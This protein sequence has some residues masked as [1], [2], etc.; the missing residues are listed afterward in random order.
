MTE[1]RGGTGEQ[2][3][4]GSGRA[5]ELVRASRPRARRPETGRRH[6]IGAAPAAMPVW[7]ADGSVGTTR[8]SAAQ[9][10]DQTAHQLGRLLATVEAG[11]TAAAADLDFER[12][13]RLRDEAEA[14]RA[15]LARR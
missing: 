2:P 1:E 14:V 5:R 9:L 8:T 12:A 6:H 4:A 3:P 13:A 11:M 10:R 7:G 15:E